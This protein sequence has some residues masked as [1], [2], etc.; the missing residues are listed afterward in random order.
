MWTGRCSELF[1]Q[2]IVSRY[3]THCMRRKRCE[4]AQRVRCRCT[5]LEVVVAPGMFPSAAHL[6]SEKLLGESSGQGS[7]G[8]AALIGRDDELSHDARGWLPISPDAP[9]V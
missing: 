2:T 9:R 4:V 6:E 8:W 7:Q 3:R 1:Q 5:I